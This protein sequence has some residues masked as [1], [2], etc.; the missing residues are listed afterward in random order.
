[1]TVKQLQVYMKNACNKM[2][3]LILAKNHDYSSRHESAFENF[4][5]LERIG[6]APAEYGFLIRLMDKL[7]RTIN[8]VKTKSLKVENE[9]IEDTL[10]DA[11]NYCLL[12]AAYL[13]E[14]SKS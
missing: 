10:L 9:K 11:A 14:R 5:V 7:M 2:Q 12:L 1:M 13:S 6:L 3:K 8:F 4:L